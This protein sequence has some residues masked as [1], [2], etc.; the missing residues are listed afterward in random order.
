MNA[1]GAPRGAN[2]SLSGGDAAEGDNATQSSTA[3]AGGARLDDFPWVY[4]LY[5]LGQTAATGVDP[6]KAQQDNTRRISFP[7]SMRRAGRSR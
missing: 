5:E 3:P 4:A 1:E 2:C 7:D 6:L